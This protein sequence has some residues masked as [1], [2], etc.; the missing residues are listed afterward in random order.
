MDSGDRVFREMAEVI[1][2]GLRDIDF[3]GVTAEDRIT[4]VEAAVAWQ[5]RQAMRCGRLDLAL[6]VQRYGL[7][8]AAQLSERA[9]GLR[10]PS[11]EGVPGGHDHDEA[12]SA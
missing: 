11:S 9:I 7:E 1:E 12:S 2:E 5:M 8:R 4:F 6:R 10:P 3:A